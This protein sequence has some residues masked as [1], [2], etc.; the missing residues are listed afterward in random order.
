MVEVD[1]NDG[2]RDVLAGSCLANLGLATASVST[3]VARGR[4]HDDDGDGE[5]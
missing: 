1:E 3:L 5:S 4:R 2:L